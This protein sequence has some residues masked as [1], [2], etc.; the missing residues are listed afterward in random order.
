VAGAALGATA[1]VQRR[2]DSEAVPQDTT[3]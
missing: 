3:S 2:I 1:L